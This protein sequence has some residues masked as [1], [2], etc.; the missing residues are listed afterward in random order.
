MS[1]ACCCQAKNLLVNG[2]KLLVN[3]LHMFTQCRSSWGWD[4]DRFQQHKQLTVEKNQASSVSRSKF[5][6]PCLC[7]SCMNI[8]SVLRCCQTAMQLQS[9]TKMQSTIHKVQWRSFPYSISLHACSIGT[10]MYWDKHALE[11]ADQ[12]HVADMSVSSGWLCL[13]IDCYL[14]SWA[15]I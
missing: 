14:S 6:Q 3:T 10:N 7:P 5:H 13:L 12:L 2:Y 1:L 15:Q 9:E 8:G 11:I 4:M